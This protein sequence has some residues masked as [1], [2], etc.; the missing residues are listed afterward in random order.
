[1][2]QPPNPSE[3]GLLE[4]ADL[5]WQDD[6]APFS[7]RYG[8]VYFSRNGGLAETHHVFLEGNLLQQRWREQ[9]AR[10]HPGVFTV[11]ELGFG[12]G[13]NFLSCWRLWQQTHCKRL[14]LH[15]ISCEKHP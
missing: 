9:D 11:C 15:Y 8:D 3:S 12:T 6:G 4:Q 10:E 1:M 7:A 5:H 2:T 14:R 13:L